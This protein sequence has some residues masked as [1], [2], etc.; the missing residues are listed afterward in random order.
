VVVRESI[1]AKKGCEM[2]SLSVG[3][4]EKLGFEWP[5]YPLIERYCVTQNGQVDLAATLDKLRSSRRFY[6]GQLSQAYAFKQQTGADYA[7]FTDRRDEYARTERALG[8]AI[9]Y[10][11][12]I[13]EAAEP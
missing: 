7:D 8:D 12:S 10:L 13:V 5:R 1:G 3:E 2:T 9:A 4:I 11:E 6:Q